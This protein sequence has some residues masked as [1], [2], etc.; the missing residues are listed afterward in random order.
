MSIKDLLYIAVIALILLVFSGTCRRAQEQNALLQSADETLQ[1][2]HNELGQ[3]EATVAALYGAIDD[4]EKL[5]ASKDSAII[6]LQKIV[7]KKTITATVL[8]NETAN[9]IT[10]TTTVEYRTDTVYKDSIAYVFPVYKTTYQNQWENFDAVASRDSF[11][12]NYKVFNEFEIKH[13]WTR[14]N[15]FS[16]KYAQISVLNL[17][18]NTETRE[19]K[20]FIVA[21]PKQNKLAIFLTGIAAGILVTTIL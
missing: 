11:K 9:T 1:L 8:Q 7:N 19:L 17:N 5:N 21:Q 20:T 12:I 4:L 16:K 6:K 14:K 2:A 15:I 10:N 3:Q 13:Q 18:P